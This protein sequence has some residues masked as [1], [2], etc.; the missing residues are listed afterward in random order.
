MYEYFE[1]ENAKDY[2]KLIKEQ[3]EDVCRNIINKNYINSQ[4]KD[5]NFGFIHK[6]NVA[7]IGQT[8][9]RKQK[10]TI[11]ISSFI[12]CKMYPDFEEI[13]I[14]LVCSRPNSKDGKMLIELVTQKAIDMK[15]KYLSL[16]SIGELKLVNWYKSQGFEIISEKAFPNGELKAYC[17]KKRI[18]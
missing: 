1:K 6:M 5:Y 3:G 12:L 10:S 11:R 16:L 8:K 18:Q 13:D 7:Q 4:S 9:S 14:S 17:M 15:F 2:E